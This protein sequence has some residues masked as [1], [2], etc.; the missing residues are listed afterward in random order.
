MP[1]IKRKNLEIYLDDEN[2]I[3]ITIIKEED[4]FKKFAINYSAKIND[5]WHAVYRV[6]NHHG[7]IHEQRLWMSNL[8]I[9]LPE[10][11][12]MDL[13]RVFDLFFDKIKEGCLRF[14]KYYED[15]IR[16]K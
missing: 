4:K 2:K 16:N 15:R 1:K 9:P 3:N 6:D 8:P 11:E 13:K 14:R 12:Y 7:F 10:Y 5:R